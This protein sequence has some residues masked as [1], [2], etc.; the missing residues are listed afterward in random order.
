MQKNFWDA[1]KGRRSIY[2][3][4]DEKIVSNERVAEIVRDAVKHV[5]SPFNSQ[6]TRTIV[7]V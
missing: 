3:L 2:G 6:S 4:S 7:A 5:P 1:V